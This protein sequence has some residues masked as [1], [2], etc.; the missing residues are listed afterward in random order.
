[1]H[2]SVFELQT[3]QCVYTKRCAFRINGSRKELSILEMD[4]D[5]REHV[6][7]RSMLEDTY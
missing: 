3:K 7:L 2:E 6:E 4:F 5:T 1:M